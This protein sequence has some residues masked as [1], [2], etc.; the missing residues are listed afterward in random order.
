[1]SSLHKIL[2]GHTKDLDIGWSPTSVILGQ[3][4]LVCDIKDLNI[5]RSPSCVIFGQLPLVCVIKDLTI[6]R[7]PS[8]VIMVQNTGKLHLWC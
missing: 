7:S 8:S 5:G 6:G 1:V 2:A 4:P 3:L